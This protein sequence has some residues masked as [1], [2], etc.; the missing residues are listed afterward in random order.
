[1]TT[2]VDVVEVTEPGL[3]YDLDETVYHADPVPDRL[4]RSLSQSGI[5]TLL[6][7]PALYAWERDHGRPIKKE[8][9]VGHAAHAQ[10]LGVGGEV[11][12]V[13][14]T[15]KDGT[16]SDATD[17]RT[18]SAQEHADAIRGEGKTPLLAEQWAHVQAAERKLREHPFA[19]LL[20]DPDR[21]RPEVSGFWQDHVDGVWCRMRLDWLPNPSES[22]RLIIPD[23]KT[24]VSADHRAFGKKA[25][26]FG[27]YIQ[28]TY[29]RAGAA[30]LGLAALPV[31]IAF[32]FVVQEKTPPYLVNVVELDV[33][34]KRLGLQRIRQ[35]L[36]VYAECQGTGIWPAYSDRVESVSLPYW[37]VR[38]TEEE[39]S[40]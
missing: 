24:A 7:A 27:Y 13:Q 12:V 14:K 26:D 23:Y 34:A 35:A 30:A 16:K 31:D 9:E 5:K 22:G 20:F 4:G 3:Y 2:T 17:Y 29:Y 18:V 33:E 36:D 38:N 25:A 19:S 40:P 21:G 8:F 32:L 11:V 1:M 28:D 10:L 15:A 37:F 39:L 6:K